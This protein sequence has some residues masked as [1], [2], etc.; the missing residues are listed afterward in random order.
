MVGEWESE[1]GWEVSPG[2]MLRAEQ[3]KYTHYREDEGEELFDL[4]R[5]PGEMRTLA[6]DPAFR[7]VLERMRA[8]LERHLRAGGDPYFETAVRIDPR[9]RSH[10][11]GYCHHTG[12]SALEVRLEEQERRE[13][14]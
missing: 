3:Y 2:R 8:L 9:W 11:V 6:R 10:P 7:P 14:R 1:G 13:G 5:D 4:E 12:P